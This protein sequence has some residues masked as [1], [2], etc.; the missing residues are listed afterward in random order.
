[1]KRV[2]EM[3]VDVIIPTYKPGAEFLELVTRLK[4]QTI[5]PHIIVMNTEKKYY[6]I[7][8]QDEKAKEILKDVS[9]THIS[10]AEF[11]HGRTR[12]LGASQSEADF[13]VMMTMDA[14]PKNSHLLEE[15]LAPFEDAEIAVSY[16]RQ[17]AKVDA[18]LVESYTRE[19]NYPAKPMK[20]S[21]ADLDRLGIKTYFCSD[22]CAAYRREVFL[23]QGGF[24][25]KAIFNEDMVYAAGAMKAGYS[26][27]YAANAMVYHS[28]NYSGAQ[29][30]H[31]NFDLGVSQAEHPEVFE[32]IRSESEGIAMVKKT[33]FYLL[34]QGKLFQVIPYIY[35]TGCK[36]I[37]F[38][39]GKKYEKLPKGLVR[40]CSGSPSYFQK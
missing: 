31:R 20:K 13:F 23:R 15:L 17:L 35:V 10:K 7:L 3:K 9:V 37:G 29:Q 5:V 14:L 6:D 39:L 22:V 38:R 27:Y 40:K 28:H 21:L 12:N 18:G 24:V 11:D 36:F 26:V 25:D 33:I 34:G 1:M 8:L 30:F 19:F 16:A 2:K 4:K 32:G